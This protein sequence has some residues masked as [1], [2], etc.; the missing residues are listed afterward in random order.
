MTE[1][2]FSYSHKDE[3]LRDDLETHLAMLKRQGLIQAYHD[4][5]ISSGSELDKEIDAAMMR[6][7][8]I[9]LLVSPDFLASEYCYGVEVSKAIEKH[10]DRS[11]I[12]IPVILRP[13]EWQ[14]VPLFSKLL[15]APT[16]NK[17]VTKWADQ[18]DA[19]LD[20]TKR[21]RSA[22]SEV[23]PK[24]SPEPELINPSIASPVISRPRSS[25]LSIK[26]TLTDHD[27]D[28]FLDEGFTY[29]RNFFESSLSE[30]EGRHADIATRFIDNG[31]QSFSAT[32]YRDGK[33]ESAISVF[34]GG[35]F[36][37]RSISYVSKETPDR[38]S[39]NGS[40]SVNEDEGR[41]Y[42]DQSM[43]MFSQNSEKLSFL[44][45]AE[46]FWSTLIAPLQR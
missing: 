19:F 14:Q 37:G 39:S 22:I 27:K 15:G 34:A 33:K 10:E 45:A 17:P 5:R 35:S 44:G 18:D 38:N 8:I 4:R 41:L 43:W 24:S 32:V 23:Q 12:V 26:T 11:A 46:L 9:L 25:N 28:K 6:A 7:G 1:L 29:I 20:V 2:F 31:G 40:L 16:D 42:F 13:C 36:G 30:L 3:T 21:I